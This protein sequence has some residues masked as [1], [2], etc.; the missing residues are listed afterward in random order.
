[1]HGCMDAC[2]CVYIDMHGHVCMHMY[3]HTHACTC[4]GE[5][6]YRCS[7]ILELY[8]EVVEFTGSEEDH[9]EDLDHV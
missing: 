7:H 1:M 3:V 9:V 5:R 4:M 8:S 6:A 2:M